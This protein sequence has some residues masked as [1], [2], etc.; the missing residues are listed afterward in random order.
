MPADIRRASH[1][2]GLLPD[3][4]YSVE[5][6]LAFTATRPQEEHWEPIEGRPVLNASPTTWH[7]QIA[8]NVCAILLRQRDQ[9]DLPWI[10]SIGVGARVSAAPRSLPHPDAMVRPGHVHRV[11]THAVDDMLVLFEVLSS[12]NRPADG[13]WRR[14]AYASLP[15]CRHCFTV[16]QRRAVVVCHDRSSRGKGRTF[17]GLDA[18]MTLPELGDEVALPL[19]DIYR[20]TPVGAVARP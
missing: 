16:E 11:N 15:N 13:A 6:Y 7:Q 19:R 1:I 4:A 20:F 9:H 5:D 3:K 2:P 18:I 10:A 17:K 14:T 8:T 12:S